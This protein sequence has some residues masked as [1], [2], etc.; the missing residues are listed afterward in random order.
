MTQGGNETVAPEAC[1][2][3]LRP[4]IAQGGF[5]VH[6]VLLDPLYCDRII[7]RWQVYGKDDA[8]LEATGPQ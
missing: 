6:G 4:P 8:I 2:E 3:G 5:A 7:R 1:H